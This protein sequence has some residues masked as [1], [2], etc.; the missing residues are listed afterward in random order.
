MK[1]KPWRQLVRRRDRGQRCTRHAELRPGARMPARVAALLRVL[2]HRHRLRIVELL[3]ERPHSVGELAKTLRLALHVASQ[4]LNHMK[5]HGLLAS[6]AGP[7]GVLPR[8]QPVRAVP[9]RMYPSTSNGAALNQA[10]HVATA[11]LDH[12]REGLASPPAWMAMFNVGGEQRTR[13]CEDNR[14]RR[15]GHGRRTQD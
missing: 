6:P 12:G 3:D 2:A 15:R 14:I 8:R 7:G 11:T 13:T 10:C 1:S 5:A 4:H 9:G